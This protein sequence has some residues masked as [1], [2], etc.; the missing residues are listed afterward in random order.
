MG[1][2]GSSVGTTRSHPS[3]AEGRKV[4]VDTST[5]VNTKAD[6]QTLTS[7]D[8]TRADKLFSE[9]ETTSLNP[10]NNKFT[11]KPMQ[12]RMIIGLVAQDVRRSGR[13]VEQAVDVYYLKQREIVASRPSSVAATEARTFLG[14][15]ENSSKAVRK[16]FN[17]DIWRA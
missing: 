5:E 8:A 15:Y 6:Q 2:R 13:T 11:M 14:W 1:G 4:Q 12:R 10:R 7:V 9:S 3:E 17:A 16:K